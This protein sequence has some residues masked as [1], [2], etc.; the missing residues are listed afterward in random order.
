MYL[1]GRER[2][3]LQ[4]YQ[5]SAATNLIAWPR[6]ATLQLSLDSSGYAA[7]HANQDGHKLSP[8]GRCWP[9]ACMSPSHMHSILCA[10][11]LSSTSC[12]NHAGEEMPQTF[13]SSRCLILP[14]EAIFC[15]SFLSICSKTRH[16]MLK[17]ASLSIVYILSLLIDLY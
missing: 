6:V 12:I 4:R 10:S 16:S 13:S 2:H 11:Q 14:L 7:Q 5:N 3:G 17:Y 9:S 1:P 15:S 8:T